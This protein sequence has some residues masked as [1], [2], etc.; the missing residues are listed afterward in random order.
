MGEL[1]SKTQEEKNECVRRIKEACKNKPMGKENKCYW[2]DIFEK[3]LQFNDGHVYYPC[4][5]FSFELDNTTTF[6]QQFDIFENHELT[7]MLSSKAKKK[8]NLLTWNAMK[9]GGIKIDVP[10]KDVL[11]DKTAKN[12]LNGQIGDWKIIHN[13]HLVALLDAKQPKI[14]T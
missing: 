11:L 1:K 12:L 13:V 14:Y 2:D 8:F 9:L 3:S 7:F 5:K 10:N 6:K 4:G